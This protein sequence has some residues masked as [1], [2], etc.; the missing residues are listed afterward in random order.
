[1][2]AAFSVR[3]GHGDRAGS[4]L[5]VGVGVA[6]GEEFVGNVGGG[7]YK[8]FTAVG[9]VTNTAARLT[10]CAAAGEIVVDASTYDAV[11]S[12][13]PRNRS[14][15]PVAQRKER[16]RLKLLDSGRSCVMVRNWWWPWWI[17][18]AFDLAVAVV[19]FIGLVRGN[20]PCSADRLRTRSLHCACCCGARACRDEAARRSDAAHGHG[21]AV[22]RRPREALGLGLVA[23]LAVTAPGARTE[24]A[25]LSRQRGTLWVVNKTLN[26]VTAFDELT[27]T[28]V[29]TVPVAGTLTPSSSPD[30]KAY[31]T[32]EDSNDVT[33]ISTMSHTVVTTILVLSRPHHIRRNRDGSRR[34]RRRVQREQGRGD[35]HRH[36]QAR[37][38]DHRRPQGPTRRRTP[39][40]LTRDGK[41]LL[42]ANEAT[43]SVT[44][45]DLASGAIVGTV[46]TGGPPSEVLA[47]PDGK[48]A[49]VS[50]RAGAI[51]VVD[52]AT[53]AI[54]GNLPEHRPRPPTRCS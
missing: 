42:A 4:W 33:V 16:A 53:R 20:S 34:L 40:W 29:A 36:R 7:G 3:S 43:N 9:D 37:K 44:I 10:S 23:L 5:G 8:D 19:A 24:S 11:R 26:N 39:T 50:L 49:Y 30:S 35:R 28:L 46:P 13:F 51:K 45:V 12:S 38:R 41:L 17:S 31:V 27:G 54:V 15:G 32:N 1:M 18:T 25:K 48:T 47:T 14:A 52:L 2:R 21:D 22:S 6:S